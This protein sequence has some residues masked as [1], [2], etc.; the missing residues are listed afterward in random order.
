[1]NAIKKNT[2]ILIDAIKEV[3]IEVQA[4]K[5]NNVALLSQE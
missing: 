5:I 3:D 2:E 1:M 4:E